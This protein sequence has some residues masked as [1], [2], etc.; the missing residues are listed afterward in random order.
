MM[1]CAECGSKIEKSLI[2]GSR[3]MC[4]NGYGYWYSMPPT[5]NDS[6]QYGHPPSITIS[7]HGTHSGIVQSQTF[8]M[9]N[10]ANWPRTLEAT[11][12]RYTSLQA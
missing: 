10:G 4:C 7:C 12:P 1:Y 2:H 5:A 9:Y 3:L 6:R 11:P 8:W